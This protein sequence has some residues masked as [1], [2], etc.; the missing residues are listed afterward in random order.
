[1]SCLVASDTTTL[2]ITVA[3]LSRWA[4]YWFRRDYGKSTLSDAR[5]GA[6]DLQRPCADCFCRALLPYLRHTLS[7]MPLTSLSMRRNPLRRTFA[8]STPTRD[9]YISHPYM[10]LLIQLGISL[11]QNEESNNNCASDT[12]QLYTIYLGG[13]FRRLY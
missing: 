12:V 2:S 1:M 6:S 3:D 8:Q 10:M 7:L 11:K 4:A 5:Q 13:G 9:L